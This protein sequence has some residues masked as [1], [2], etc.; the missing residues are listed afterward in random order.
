MLR[1]LNREP[2][3]RF[4]NAG[5]MKTAVETWTKAGQEHGP[6]TPPSVARA[7]RSR[8]AELPGH[9]SNKLQDADRNR[10]VGIVAGGECGNFVQNQRPF[11]RPIT[12]LAELRVLLMQPRA[13]QMRSRRGEPAR[14][15]DCQS[16]VRHALPGRGGGARPNPQAPNFG[17]VA[18]RGLGVFQR[19]DFDQAIVAFDELIRLDP[20]HSEG[21]DGV[22][23]PH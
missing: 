10:A 19:S 6:E 8:F 23:T 5:Q 15:G 12:G 13:A 18:R 14:S 21:P 2:E 22:A 11:F 4:Q 9:S 16:A 17:E 1:A 3:L 7:N 20:R